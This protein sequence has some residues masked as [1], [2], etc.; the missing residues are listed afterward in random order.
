[1]DELIIAVAPYPSE[2]QVERFPGTLDVPDELIRCH[3]AGA[4][5]GHLHVRD[6]NGIQTPD[7]ALFEEHVGTVHARC[8]L[9]IEGSTGGTPENT[10]AERCVSFRV[11]GVEVGSLNLGSVNMYGAVFANPVDEIDY[12]L[13][14]LTARN[15]KPYLDCF[16][17]SHVARVQELAAAG[18]LQSPHLF[19][20]VLGFPD[21]LPYEDRY[22][23]A[24][25]ADL[26]ADSLWV[27]HRYHAPGAP[28]F[29]RALERGGHVRV[30]YEDG[31]FLANG[32]RARS[33]AELVEEAVALARS[34][35]RTVVGPERARELLGLPAPAFAMLL[36]YPR[37]RH[38]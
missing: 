35:G 17:L 25:V 23:D 12:Y 7:T 37:A 24:L 34:V 4:S 1:M 36:E 19:G 31:P 13:G 26:P 21:A 22:L 28:G 33:N 5:I 15:L 6:A 16:D 29:M 32:K 38:R 10:R 9:I 8:P 14:E 30:G 3:D 27:L 18:R 11:K 2:K 20:L